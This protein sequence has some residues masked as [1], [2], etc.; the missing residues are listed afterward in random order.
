MNHVRTGVLMKHL[1]KDIS[2]QEAH[3]TEDS[4]DLNWHTLRTGPYR[5]R[6]FRGLSAR[7]DLGRATQLPLSQ[8]AIVFLELRNQLLGL[9]QLLFQF[10]AAR[11]AALR[12]S[13]GDGRGKTRLLF[14]AGLLFDRGL[15]FG[16]SS[17]IV[18]WR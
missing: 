14:G 8:T 12:R 5:L 16:P 4:R 11:L 2:E 10:F 13:D 17:T 9:D 15:R 3:E 18:A 7:F 6:E 1:E